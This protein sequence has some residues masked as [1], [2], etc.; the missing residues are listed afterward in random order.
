MRWSAWRDGYRIGP[1][2]L[3]PAQAGLLPIP[4][5]GRVGAVRWLEPE[6]RASRCRPCSITWRSVSVSGPYPSRNTSRRS[7]RCA[8]TCRAMRTRSRAAK[9]VAGVLKVDHRDR[10]RRCPDQVAGVRSRRATARDDG[11]ERGQGVQVFL[12]N[13]AL[14]GRGRTDS[15][16]RSHC[17]PHPPHVRCVIGVVVV[18]V[19]A[20]RSCGSDPRRRAP[21]WRCRRGSA[22]VP[23]S[24]RGG[25]RCATTLF[26]LSIRRSPGSS[27]PGSTRRAQR[28]PASLAPPSTHG[29][30]QKAA[31]RTSLACH[32]P[33]KI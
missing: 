19:A 27:V 31:P 14:V 18:R 15:A 28:A 4:A 2:S 9:V 32:R 7:G 24:G 1:W 12:D 30:C 5:V 3:R 16:R 25:P 6:G 10:R 13:G 11:T 29:P 17:A 20:R 26:G 33:T 8:Q 23:S 21:M 22:V